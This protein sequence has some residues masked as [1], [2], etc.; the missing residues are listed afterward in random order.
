MGAISSA[1]LLSSLV[2]FNLAHTKGQS[3]GGFLWKIEVEP[4]S[5]LFGTIHVSHQQVWKY[6]SE[7]AKVALNYSHVIYTE[8][9][10]RSRDYIDETIRCNSRLPNKKLS[11]QL[12]KKIEIY[13]AENRDKDKLNIDS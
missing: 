3:Q 1:T 8:V 13:L 11:K 7:E 12:Y 6:V 4:P 2:L 9:D 10:K 5:Y